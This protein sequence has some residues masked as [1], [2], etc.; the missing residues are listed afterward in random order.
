M[1]CHERGGNLQGTV[2]ISGLFRVETGNTD[3]QVGRCGVDK[4]PHQFT[5]FEA[6]HI[7]TF[8]TF[9]LSKFRHPLDSLWFLSDTGSFDTGIGLA[10]NTPL[11]PTCAGWPGTTEYSI[12]VLLRG[13]TATSGRT[14][15]GRYGM[16]LFP[17]LGP[18]SLPN[19]E[20][21]V[22]LRVAMGDI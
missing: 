6:F 4:E 14:K 10:S 8:F 3:F 12:S 20:P 11:S 5:I 18:T 2:S 21:Q 19:A 7:G 13:N 16:T 9:F 22:P 1:G 15:P 17:P